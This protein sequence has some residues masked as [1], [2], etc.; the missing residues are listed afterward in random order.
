MIQDFNLLATSER[1]RESE[2]CSELWMLLRA[3]G[4]DGPAVDRSRIRGLITARTSLNPVEAVGMLRG[5]LRA[6]PSHFRALLRVMPVE[7]VV[8]TKPEEIVAAAHGLA[9]RIGRDESFRITVEKRGTEL[10]SMEIIDAVAQGID[11]RVDLGS[12]DWIVLV[13]IVGKLTGVSVIRREG[14]LNVQKERARLPADG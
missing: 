12:P 5:E 1:L 2:A 8:Q 13:E 11:Q 4:D 9:S 6:R 3:V 7:A 14:L 10:R